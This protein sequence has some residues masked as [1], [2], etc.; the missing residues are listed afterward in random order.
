MTRTRCPHRT[1]IA[2]P[3]LLVVAA[4]L[5]NGCGRGPDQPPLS[6]IDRRELLTDADLIVRC[7]D[8]GAFSEAVAR[9]P[10]GL[11]WHGPEMEAFREGW[12]FEEI[13]ARAV[14][15]E[16]AGA[17]A[18]RMREIY[19]EQL[20]LLD[21]EFVLGLDFG[22]F[23]RAPAITLAAAIRAEDYQRSL[24]MDRLL[25]E[26][27]PVETITAREDF[28]G[29]AI[30]TYLR[31]EDD[32]DRFLYQA[33]HDGTLLASEDR[34]W[35]EQSLIRL[36][37]ARAREPEG[38]PVLTVTGTARL[39]DRLQA[40]MA[41]Q[42]AEKGA[43][44]DAQTVLHGLGLDSV[45]D[46]QLQ[47]AMKADRTELV[48]QAARR[49][50]WNRGLM[51]LVPG[52]PVPVDFRLA[53]VPRDVA[54]Y[55]VFRVDL[56]A[57]WR[58]IP[59]LL[60][61]ISPDHQMQFSMGVNA[62]GGL[63]NIDLNEEIFGNLDRLGFTY[64]RI[65]DAGQELVYGFRVK[66]AGAMARTLDKLF[67]EHAPVR[68]Q[69]GEI[70]RRTDIQGHSVH[71]LQFPVPA[72]HGERMTMRQVGMT[73]VDRALVIGE[74]DLLVEHVQAAVHNQGAAEFYTSRMFT[75]MTRR[76]PAEACSYGATDLG[77]FAR[78]FIHQ[79]RSAAEDLQAAGFASPARAG[80]DKAEGLNPLADLLAGFDV[81]QLPLPESVGAFF[82]TSD[83]YS[84]MD[85][86][87]FRSTM[88]IYDPPH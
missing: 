76:V 8:A 82:G 32:G 30:T 50:E 20:K 31:K 68:A 54:G 51:V 84:L 45:G 72:G 53:Y 23:S 10:L 11:F 22:D 15:E 18:A 78:F 85:G 34:P 36:M 24:E 64:S 47:M 56:D 5:L 26:L 69:L 3:W 35:L 41:E 16:M 65:G 63:M 14:T 52:E 33:F 71:M 61:Q 79:L 19:L 83:G 7:S 27:E 21:G 6:T 25:F 73:V 9:S 37:A 74:G 58:Q 4:L 77:A 12:R 57:F 17:H 2:L 1:W 43:P 86:A 87:G 75:D 55:Q 28:R 44:F 67:A 48:F 40:L 66:D 88:T 70:Y 49:G 39:L 13:F 29:T 81:A 46:L 62:A 38:D 42:A 80:G 59:E 60:R